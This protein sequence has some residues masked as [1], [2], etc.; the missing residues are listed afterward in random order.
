MLRGT[1]ILRATRGKW[2]YRDLLRHLMQRDPRLK[3]KGSPVGFDWLLANPL[4]MATVDTVAFKYIVQV[5]A[6]RT[7][8]TSKRIARRRSRCSR[9]CRRNMCGWPRSFAPSS[10]P[11]PSAL[12]PGRDA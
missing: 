8:G 9:R 3:Y 10:A 1:R 4:L 6:D 7:A 12:L 2:V 5:P 11:L